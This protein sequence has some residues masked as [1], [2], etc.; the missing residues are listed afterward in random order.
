MEKDR[1]SVGRNVPRHGA[2]DKVTGRSV[3][4]A[5][6]PLDRPLV[7]KVIRST[8]A[9]ARIVSV[10]ADNACRLPGVVR[11]FTARD[12]PG[13]NL[14]GIINKDRP[15]LVPDKV[16]CVGD[17]I[18]LVAA[19]DEEAAAAAAASVRVDYEDLPVVRDPRKA[20]EEGAPRIH[21]TGNLLFRRTVRKGDV[22][23]GFAGCAAVVE[24]TYETSFVEH[25][26]LEPDAGAGYVDDDGT[27]VIVSSTQNP[28]YDHGEVVRLLGVDDDRSASSRGPPAAG[29]AP[30]WTS[31]SRGFIGLA[32]Y[33]LNRPVRL[34]PSR[35]KS[36]FSPPPSDTPSPSC[37]NRCR[38][39][40]APCGHEGPHPVRHRRLRLLRHRGGLPGRGARHRTL[41]IEHVEV[42]ALCA[43][44]NHPFTG[45]MRGF[46]APQAAFAHESQMDLLAAELGLDPLRYGASMPSSPAPSPRRD[47]GSRRAW[48]WASA[49]TRSGPT[50]TAACAE[51]R[52][53]SAAPFERRGVGVGAMWYGIA[54]R[55][56]QN[57][58]TAQVG[59]DTDGRVTVYTGLRRH[60]PGIHHRPRQI[61]AE[62]MGLAPH[63]IRMVVADTKHTTNAGATSASRQT[64][65]SGN[66]VR[67]AAG[68]LADV[69]LT[70]AVDM[71]KVPK[72]AWCS[73]GVRCA[74]Q[75]DAE[76]T[77]SFSALAARA[78]R[79]GIPLTWQGYFDPDT[80]P[81]DPETGQGA[82]YATYAFACHL[83]LVSVGHT[84]GAGEGAQ[85][86]GGP[87][88]GQGSSSRGGHRADLRRRGHG[89]RLRP[90][91]EYT[92][93][94]TESMKDYFIPTCR[95]MPE[96]IPI[97]V[98]AHE[99]TGPFGAKGVGEPALIPTAPAVVNAITDALGER[100][101]RLPANL[102]R[103][104]EA[105]ITAG[106][107]RP[108]EA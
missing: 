86:R 22:E 62:V 5:D 21:D 54:T 2:V 103:V 63:M 108:K 27:L 15:L 82:P 102:E 17:A 51:W 104:L 26:Y 107:F 105:S 37:Q 77:A 88:R 93:E 47:R 100:I 34:R 9:H 53:G 11:V 97:I 76:K 3:F 74:P 30:N 72:D 56:V 41:Q 35:G 29:S 55:G 66:A 45:A 59:I 87:R 79:K 95:D 50:T 106:H 60:R 92:P 61:A 98:E 28:H 52:R 78:R 24:R 12:I 43:Y 57:P 71:L 48:A 75:D 23:K 68:K 96:V 85:D 19:E 46:G 10:D 67:D 42:E 7:L 31:P 89:A 101:Y 36:P 81:L 38:P 20:L 1:T 6:L 90:H 73:K 39:G 44:T 4:S 83:A 58:S 32:L 84:H 18:A 13:K 49:W 69:L 99:P 40:R 65:I 25:C 64:Y 91:G 16:R 70:E 33:H 14:I 94:V 80:V 8:R